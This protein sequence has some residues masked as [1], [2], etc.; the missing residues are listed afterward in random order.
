MQKR[1]KLQTDK[2]L[3]RIVSDG[4]QRFDETFDL[5]VAW[6]EGGAAY[7]VAEHVKAARKAA[8]IHID[9]ESA[10]YTKEMDQG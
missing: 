8:F 5:A 10:G 2:L 3:W 7:Y 1:G 4:A 9:Y 6:L